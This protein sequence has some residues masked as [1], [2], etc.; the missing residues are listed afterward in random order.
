[1]D[2]F[3]LLFESGALLAFLL[4]L[5]HERRSAQMLEALLLAF[6]YGFILEALNI[7][8]SGRFYEYSNAFLLQFA[9]VPLSIG[10]GWGTIYYVARRYA[11]QFHLAWWQ[12]PLLMALVALS[13]DL[14]LDVNAIRL[15]FWHWKIPLGEEWFGVPYDN[16]FGWLA[17]MWTFALLLNYSYQG[18]LKPSLGKLIRRTAPFTAALLLGTQ[19]MLYQY[20]AALLSGKFTLAQV[21]AFSPEDTSY[22]L[23][24]EVRTIRTYIFTLILVLVLSIC[25]RWIRRAPQPLTAPDSFTSSLSLAIHISFLFFLFASGIYVRSPLLLPVALFAAAST[26]LLDRGAKGTSNP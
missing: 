10:A 11:E 8:M 20:A 26:V 2:L 18:H 12:I 17:V 9:G 25:L 16:F 14:S 7:R 1:M 6:S 4:I 23:V 5:R 15:G 19:I 22:A 24:P 3:F 21:L 13:F